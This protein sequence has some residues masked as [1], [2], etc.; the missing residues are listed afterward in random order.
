MYCQKKTSTEKEDKRKQV[1][2]RQLYMHKAACTY[3]QRE[4]A[5]DLGLAVCLAPICS[6]IYFGIL[7][8]ELNLCTYY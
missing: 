5:T 4:Q 3:A 8:V 2:K 1:G 6:Q 7:C